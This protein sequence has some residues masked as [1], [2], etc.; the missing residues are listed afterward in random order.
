M[1][2]N[3]TITR[4]GSGGGPEFIRS[5]RSIELVKLQG[6]STAVDDT[7]TYNVQTFKPDANTFVIGGGFHVSAVSGQQVTITSKIAL[8]SVANYVYI[9]SAI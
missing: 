6:S 1:P 5:P 4:A 7:G 8:G 2:A 9:A 3:I